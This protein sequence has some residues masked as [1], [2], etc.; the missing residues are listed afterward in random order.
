M[1]RSGLVDSLTAT[2][3]F[4]MSCML[5]PYVI[6]GSRTSEGAIDVSLPHELFLDP[7][8]SLIS[9]LALPEGFSL[10]ETPLISFYR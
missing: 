9:S 10:T 1:T 7:S 2:Q 5:S 4:S 6:K 3:M 8:S